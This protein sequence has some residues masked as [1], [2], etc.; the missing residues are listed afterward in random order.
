MR[1]NIRLC[2]VKSHM[3]QTVVRD[4]DVTFTLA[5]G[6]TVTQQVRGNHQRLVR[7]PCGKTVRAVRVTLLETW[8]F[9]ECRLF[10]F[11]L[12]EK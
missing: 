5:D 10:A 11:D 3:P 2:H 7:I 12:M 9:S 1:H 8:G 4:F 6:T